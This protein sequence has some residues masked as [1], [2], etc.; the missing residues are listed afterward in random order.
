MALHE[1]GSWYTWSEERWSPGLSVS[2]PRRARQALTIR[3]YV[4]RNLAGLELRLS[5][6]TLTAVSD[7]EV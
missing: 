5:Q 7:A 6:Q 2:G 1:P 4:P 3:A